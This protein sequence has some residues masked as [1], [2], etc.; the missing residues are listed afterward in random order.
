MTYAKEP[1]RQIAADYLQRYVDDNFSE[2]QFLGGDEHRIPG[3]DVIYP[4]QTPDF[5]TMPVL[6]DE[7]YPEEEKPLRWI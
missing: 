1:K 2:G 7:P 5:Y 3:A 6:E 4:G